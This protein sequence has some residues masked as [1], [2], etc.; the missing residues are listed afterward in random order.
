LEDN[1]RYS[2]GEGLYLYIPWRSDVYINNCR[3]RQDLRRVNCDFKDKSYFDL[4]ISIPIN[5]VTGRLVELNKD[6][7]GDITNEDRGILYWYLCDKKDLEQ[8]YMT[9]ELAKTSI[10]K[11]I[12]AGDNYEAQIIL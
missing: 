6:F 11:I 2:N 9:D 1:R 7:L 3:Y 12:K 4:Y 10:L 5:T 8:Y